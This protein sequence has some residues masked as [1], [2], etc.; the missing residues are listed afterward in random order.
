MTTN[1]V[2]TLDFNASPS[3][4]LPEWKKNGSRLYI[5]PG[6]SIL[7]LLKMQ[8]DGRETYYGTYAF[9]ANKDYT[10][11]SF[12]AQKT[13]TTFP[14]VHCFYPWVDRTIFDKVIHLE[15]DKFSKVY[16]IYADKP[17]DAFYVFNPRVMEY[18]LEPETV[19][20]LRSFETVGG[21]ILTTF[22]TNR[23]FSA[24]GRSKKPYIRFSDYETVKEDILR[25]LDIATDLNDTLSREI[26]DDGTKRSVAK[27]Q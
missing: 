15:G 10:Y 5:D 11:T 13:K 27:I 24:V 25:K 18:M 12:V 1:E 4:Q 7:S 20:L 23:P 26:V 6:D 22:T 17:E 3:D 2:I 9:K 21:Y 16:N 14:I 8:Y 19:K